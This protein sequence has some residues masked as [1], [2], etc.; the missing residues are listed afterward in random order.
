ME[1]NNLKV[2]ETQSF[3][4][5]SAAVA[6][7]SALDIQLWLVEYLAELL[8]VDSSDINANA[9]FTSYGLDSLTMAGMASDLAIWLGRELS[10][11]S[12]Y[13]FPSIQELAVHLAN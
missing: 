4:A 2:A 3:L 10:P 7:P 1:S 8:E 13:K 6:A 5:S 12:A 9:A 11:D